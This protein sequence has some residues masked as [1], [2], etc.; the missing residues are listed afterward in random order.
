MF[1]RAPGRSAPRRFRRAS[2]RA[3]ARPGVW[4]ATALPCAI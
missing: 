4:A 2:S 3:C 1:H